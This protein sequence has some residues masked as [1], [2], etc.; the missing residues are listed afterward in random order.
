MC[1]AE[2]PTGHQLLCSQ[3]LIGKKSGLFLIYAA[4]TITTFFVFPEET[5]WSWADWAARIK[6]NFEAHFYV[7]L[8]GPLGKHNDAKLVNRRGIYKDSFG[9]TH[10]WPDYQLRPNFC[11]A[12]AVVC[13]SLMFFDECDRLPPFLFPMWSEKTSG[14]EGLH[15]LVYAIYLSPLSLTRSVSY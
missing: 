10:A 14:P 8:E 5:Y 7:P 3:L 11:L 13:G 9:A 15:G 1:S 2:C 6:A 12:I 4:T